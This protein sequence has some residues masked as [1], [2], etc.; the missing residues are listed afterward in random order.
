VAP[1]Q[2]GPPALPCPDLGQAWGDDEI[3]LLL[4]DLRRSSQRLPDTN[5]LVH[6]AAE[7]LAAGK[8][9][10]W[11]QGR[12]EWGPRALG[13][14]SILAD[15]CQPGMQERVN[16]TVKF[17]EAFRPF[18]PS[19]LQDAA[20]RYFEIPEAA[21]LLLPWMLAVVP[22]KPEARALLPSV[23]HV[24][25]TARLQ[26]VTPDGNPR[27]AALLA[28]VGARTGHPVLLNTSF[29]LKGEPIVS[30]PVH[31]LATFD[32]SALDVLYLGNHR[33]ERADA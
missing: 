17:R 19:C 14:R 3:G 31:A 23:T 20:P 21:R 4:T 28:A 29:N 13:H 25:G 8:V 24:D 7:D 12:F 30:S 10:G 2:G 1:D 15:P 18:A 27:Y 32:R 5:A 6:A 26:T 9:I 33:V 22:V 16:A 11:F